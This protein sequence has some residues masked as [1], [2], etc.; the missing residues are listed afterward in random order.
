MAQEYRR[1]VQSQLPHDFNRQVVIAGPNNA[2][3][4]QS[5]LI[6]R[7]R[8]KLRER[9][10]MSLVGLGRIFSMMDTSGQAMLDI[11]EF[12]NAIQ[13][14]CLQINPKDIQSLFNSMDSDRSGTISFHEFIG[15]IAGPLTQFRKDLVLKAFK[16]L[17]RMNRGYVTVG[18]IKSAYQAGGHPDARAGKRT[19]DEIEDEFFTSF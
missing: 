13:D 12:Q 7:F 11:N 14:Y 8:A 1:E 15:V 4:F 3:K 9:G 5:I 10:P 18:E 17:D 2:P 16:G 6:E 19:E